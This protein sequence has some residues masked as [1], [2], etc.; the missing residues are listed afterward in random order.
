MVLLGPRFERGDE[1]IGLLGNS[2]EGLRLLFRFAYVLSRPISEIL[3]TLPSG[4]A[5]SWA[6][7]LPCH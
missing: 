5:D 3:V 4:G 6:A 7:R 1:G 2:W